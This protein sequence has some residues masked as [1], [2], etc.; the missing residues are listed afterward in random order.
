MAILFQKLLNLTIT[1]LEALEESLPLVLFETL[2][3]STAQEV[4]SLFR[5]VGAGIEIRTPH[6][7]KLGIRHLAFRRRAAA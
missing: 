5:G 7:R 2:N 1:D 3:F 6:E 4:Y